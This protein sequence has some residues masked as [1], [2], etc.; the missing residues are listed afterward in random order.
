MVVEAFGEDAHAGDFVG[1]EH[2]ADALGFFSEEPVALGK[3]V[4]VVGG[5]AEDAVNLFRV[6]WL[7]E[8][9]EGPA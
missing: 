7:V 3:G 5:L 2:V 6:P 4:V 9:A 8:V 1:G